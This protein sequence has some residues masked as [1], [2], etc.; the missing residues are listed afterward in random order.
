MPAGPDRLP[1]IDLQAP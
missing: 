1:L